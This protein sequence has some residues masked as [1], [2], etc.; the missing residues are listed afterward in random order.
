MGKLTAKVVENLTT[1]GKYEDGEGLRLVI[2]DSGRKSWVFRYQVANKRREKGLGSYPAVSLKDARL[3]ASELRLELQAGHDPLYLAEQ[4][5]KA[6]KQAQ[7]LP[8]FSELCAQYIETHK[9]S[10]KNGKHANQWASTLATYAE[11]IIGQLRADEI[12]TKHILDILQPIWADKT[13][14]A[15]RIRNRIE[16][17]LDSAKAQELREGE[18]PARWRGHL[19]KLL[20]SPAKIRKRQHM[21]ALPWAELPSFWKALTEHDERSYLALRFTI[22]TACRTSEVLKARWEEI[23]LDASTWIIP[24]ERMK[25]GREHRVP[26]SSCAL[27]LIKSMPQEAS[28]YLFCSLRSPNKPM[29]NMAMLMALRRMERDDLTT[30]GFRSTF[31]DWAAENTSFPREVI[32]LCLAHSVASGAEAAYFRTDLLAKRR[33]LMQAWSEFIISNN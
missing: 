29:T 16:L 9:S 20:P 17:I 14:T 25:A 24:A 3:K 33:E 8:C 15:T 26:L 30:H 12:T 2:K 21:R 6:A 32:E 7:Q 11:P 28:P 5:K 18:N 13:E 31:R 1:K 22:L 19:D 27:E 4:A 10:W 23:D